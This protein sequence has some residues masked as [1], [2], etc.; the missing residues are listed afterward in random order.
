MKHLTRDEHLFGP[1]PKRILSLDGGGVRGMLSLEY[2]KRIEDLLRARFGHDPDFRLCDFFDLIAGTSTG[3]VIAAALVLGFRAEQ[4]QKL[5]QTLL[6]RIL[7]ARPLRLGLLKAKFEREAVL[8]ALA[9]QCG[10]ITLG[11]ASLRTGIMLALKRVDT[12]SPWLLHNNP[13]GKFNRGVGF[14]NQDFLLRNVVYASA[15]APHYFPPEHFQMAPGIEGV[16]I[17][18]AVA[19]ANNPALHALMLACLSGYGLNWPMGKERILLVSVGT[20]VAV[21]Q[22]SAGAVAR[23]ALLS[24]IS[25]LSA[26]ITDTSW[27]VQTLLQWMSDCPTRWK[28]DSEVGDL[29]EDSLVGQPCLTYLRYNTVL[30]S[31]WLQTH[32]GMQMNEV[33]IKALESIDRVDSMEPLVHIG[34]LA[35]QRQVREEHFPV[36][37]DLTVD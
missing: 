25:A 23:P 14:S 9:D 6:G 11:D 19:A 21:T 4:I 35:A 5:Y 26:A 16:F 12:G 13:R 36:S 20:G 3:A 32:L 37:F 1:G 2:L 34:N 17:D 15:A 31:T 22:P 10:D 8:Q 29:R 18:G 33:A 28:I 30:D 27:L 24:A 7:R